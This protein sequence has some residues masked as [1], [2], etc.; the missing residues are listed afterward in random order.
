[1]VLRQSGTV[2]VPVLAWVVCVLAVADAVAETRPAY[3]LKVTVLM[4]L[5]AHA[6]WMFLASPSLVVEP[7][8]VRVVNPLRVHRIPFA[9]LGEVQ[10]RG[11]TTLGYRDGA[12]RDRVVASWNAPGQPRRY[13]APVPP[14]VEVVERFRAAWADRSGAE[15][16]DDRASVVWRRVPLVVLSVLLLATIT[17]WSQGFR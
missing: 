11:L 6:A 14:V 12:G 10:V 2:M 3:A 16:R 1:M 17:I 15:Q 4:G 8:G 13:G 9:V 7:D 5:V